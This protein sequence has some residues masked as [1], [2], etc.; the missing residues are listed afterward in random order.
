MASSGSFSTVFLVMVSP[1]TPLGSSR[2]FVQRA[3]KQLAMLHVSSVQ[4]HHTSS[5]RLTF[6]FLAHLKD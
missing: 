4:L 2:L 3:Y 6:E 5:W 1:Q